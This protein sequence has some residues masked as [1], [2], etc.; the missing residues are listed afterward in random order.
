MILYSYKAKTQALTFSK[1]VTPNCAL[2]LHTGNEV[3]ALITDSL[4]SQNKE[5]EVT[6]QLVLALRV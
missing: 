5:M 3:Q 4:E 1:W 6:R 2:M